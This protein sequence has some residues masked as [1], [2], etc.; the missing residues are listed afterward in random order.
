MGRRRAKVDTD[1]PLPRGLN[2]HGRTY[3]ARRAGQ[4][5]TYF[6][7]D[8]GDAI[9]AFKAWQSAKAL[10]DTVGELLDRCAGDVW[11]S[12]VRAGTMKPRTARDYTTDIEAIKVG[13]GKC[14]LKALRPHHV[15]TYKNARAKTNPAHVRNELACLSSALSY[16]VEEGMM[17]R[18][19]CF[20]VRRPPKSVRERLVTDAEYLAVH[21]QAAESVKLAM[22][23]A[24]RTLGA[25]VDVLGLGIRNVVTYAD[26]RKTL[27]FR[28]GKTN[29]QVEVEIVGDLASALGPFLANPSLHKSFVRTR[30]GTPYTVDGIGAM[31]RRYAEK[32]GI[33]DFAL[34][35][36]RAK[37]AT[38]M[39]RAQVPI[40]H[41]QLLLGHKSVRTTE[42]YLK[43]LLTEIVRPN[44][45]PIIAEVR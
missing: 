30:E 2:L 23:L 16:A 37:G 34:R 6:G 43:G 28:R 44:E 35:D 13:L 42:I 17:E 38:D 29:V 3:R 12:R 7:K 14:P 11:P 8:Y 18:N 26:G 15:A 20:E 40:K 45:L 39:Y 24:I 25:P 1:A 31:F 32:A 19:P 21:A 22:L 9:K 10:P 5:W 27:R 41:I 33:G 36:L 4:K